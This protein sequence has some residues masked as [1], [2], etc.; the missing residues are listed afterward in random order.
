[1]NHLSM[2]HLP[3]DLSQNFLLPS[4]APVAMEARKT[5][6]SRPLE[7]Q[8]TRGLKAEKWWLNHQEMGN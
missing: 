5:S 4:A 2:N 7:A 1:M 3:R 6:P 8:T